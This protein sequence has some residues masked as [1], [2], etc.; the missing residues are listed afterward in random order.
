MTEHAMSDLAR[1]LSLHH[2]PTLVFGDGCADQLRGWL[3]SRG[4][5]RPFVLTA[6]AT[7]AIADALL[8]DIAS[9]AIWNGISGEPGLRT[10]HEALAVARSH[11][12]DTIVGIGG[13]SVLDVAKVVAALRDSDQT[14]EQIIG[15]GNLRTRRTPLVCLPTT[16]GT[17]SEVSPNAILLDEA[18]SLKKGIISPHLVPDAAFVDPLLT[19]S[20][21]PAVTAATGIDA[22]VH[23]I[24]AYANRRAHPMVD[25]YALEGIR[26]I[27]R[28]LRR[29]VARGHDAD[30]RRDVAF[31]SLLGGLCLGPVNTGAVHALAYPLGSE[32]GIAHGVSNAVMLCEV[33]AYNLPAAPDRYADIAIAL[34]ITRTDADMQTAAR[35][36]DRLRTLCIECGMP[37]RI[38]EL[39]IPRDAL[40]RMAASAIT[41]RRLLDLNVRELSL[42]DAISIYERAY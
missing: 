34:G 21:P 19:H 38:H 33:L 15:I 30:A 24:E 16:A 2:P 13:G 40:P 37:T 20:V 42:D 32:F 28:S 12:A 4:A 5:T 1:I 29:A 8:S 23:C 7:R 17:G 31:G 6:P 27:H 26:R 36:L 22:L 11:D 25:L 18:A 41:I 39:G 14:P 3:A 35:G 9:A 10:L